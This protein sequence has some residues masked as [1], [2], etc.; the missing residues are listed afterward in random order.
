MGRHSELFQPLLMIEDSN[1]KIDAQELLA[2]TAKGDK[3]AF[4]L[5]YTQVFTPVFRYIFARIRNRADAEDLTQQT[6]IK[7]LRNV[8]TFEARSPSPLPYF[9]TAARNLIIDRAAKR[10]EVPIDSPEAEPTIEAEHTASPER[11]AEKNERARMIQKALEVLTPEQKEV[12]IL[13]FFSNLSVEETAEVMTKNSAAVRQLQVRALHALR[14][15][16]EKY[17]N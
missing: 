8:K 5:L 14:R 6:F 9:F 11:E 2:R 4:G 10:K 16:L 1:H 13:R 17:P 3:E 7:V 12:L 15:H